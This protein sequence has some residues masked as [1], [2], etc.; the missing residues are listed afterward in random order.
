[1]TGNHENASV[2]LFSSQVG[3]ARTMQHSFTK[4][5]H[6]ELVEGKNKPLAHNKF[7]KILDNPLARIM[8]KKGQQ[9]SKPLFKETDLIDQ[10]E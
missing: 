6:Q 3:L 7:K 4:Q 1:M 5:K 9:L 2:N 8:S 10:Q